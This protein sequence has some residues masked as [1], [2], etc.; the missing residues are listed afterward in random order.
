MRNSIAIATASLVTIVGAGAALFFGLSGG[1]P[2]IDSAIQAEIGRSL[3]QEALK[4]VAAGGKLTVLK[5]DT[6]AFKQPATDI[7][8]AQF[9]KEIRRAHGPAVAVQALSVDPLR[10]V[11]VPGGDFFELLRR[12]GPAD[13]I[14]SFM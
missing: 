12:G 9:E 4:L 8:F 5:R 1:R 3:A 11:Q 2:R 6:T 14:V 7:V 10:P 13:V